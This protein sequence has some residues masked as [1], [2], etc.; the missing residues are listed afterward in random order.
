MAQQ[1]F[2]FP[3][4]IPAGTAKATPQTTQMTMP[5]RIVDKV[6]IEVPPGPRGE[7]GF[8]LGSKGTQIIP[9]GVGT[10]IV[11][12]GETIQW[13]LE[14]QMDSGGWEMVAYNTGFYSHTITARFLVRMPGAAGGAAGAP[15]PADALGAVPSS[16]GTVV[17]TLTNGG[18]PAGTSV[19]ALP[20]P[21]PPGF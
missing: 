16:A 21:V 9:D 18:A 11:T 12:D 10:Y 20:P 14:G 1:V 13:P 5:P 4:T 8:H 6:E 17:P 19:A 15:I 2:I 3:V 7:V